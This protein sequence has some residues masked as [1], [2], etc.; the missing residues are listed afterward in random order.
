MS[1]PTEFGPLLVA[2]APCFT[3]PTLARFQVLLL[4]ATLAPGRRTVS[5]LLRTL[6]G[7]AVGHP[8]SYRRVLSAAE[9]SGLQLGCALARLVLARLPADQ[10]VV[11]VGDDTVDGHPGKCVYGK[12]RHRDPVRSSKSHTAWRYGHKWVVLAVVVH[13]PFGSRP[14]ALPVLVDLYRSEAD[15]RK[16]KR[17]HRTPAQLMCRLLRVVL[18]RF[19][20]RRF[21]FVGDTAYGTHE[22]ARFCRRHAG[23]LTLVS[24]LHPKAN[25]YEPPPPYSGRGRPPKKGKALPKPI[26]AAEACLHAG[27]PGKPERVTV[28]WY[29][30]GEREAEVVTG[31]GQWY[32]A[33]QDLVPLVWVFVR[34]ATGTHRDEFFYSTDPAMGAVEMV[35]RYTRRW[36][37][38]TTFQEAREYLGLESTKGWC[39]KTVVRAGPCLLCLYTVV[40]LAYAD[41]PEGE[42]SGGI[43]WEGK[44]H[45]TFSD[46]LCC[47]RRRLWAEAVLPQAD[48]D[49]SVAKLAPQLR[50]LLLSSLAPAA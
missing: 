6:G 34:D 32:K 38:E 43:D 48:P 2:L 41:T 40:A 15:D 21:V 9:W 5:N 35:T 30:G 8:S 4:A 49:G 50:E 28:G 1:F 25:L 3:A 10:P 46:A 22:S 20:D 27:V 26:V 18:L 45:A 33:G 29:G 7:L 14:W 24:K 31:Q 37:I 13:F 16:R 42:R 12:A 36:N 11:L 23:R 39:E 17:R 44:A 19:P 47:V